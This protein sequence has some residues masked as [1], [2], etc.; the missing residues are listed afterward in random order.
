MTVYFACDGGTTVG[1]HHGLISKADLDEVL[2]EHKVT[3]MNGEE[4]SFFGMDLDFAKLQTGLM[5]GVQTLILSNFYR[6]VTPAKKK[7]MSAIV[8]SKGVHFGSN[9][10]TS[11]ANKVS[12]LI[13][14]TDTSKI[15]QLTKLI[16]KAAKMLTGNFEGSAL[17]HVGGGQ[18]G[19]GKTVV[20]KLNLL[21]LRKY[22]KNTGLL[23]KGLLDEVE[24][25][26]ENVRKSIFNYLKS[27]TFRT[28]LSQS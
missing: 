8:T 24:D 3:D 20:L 12:L 4:Y 27:E 28:S 19:G 25:K 16:K 2:V 11:V 6:S 18:V 13:K 23:D 7:F 17:F 10:M 21:E 1:G 22:L 14:K 15:N 5:A 9:L 26:R